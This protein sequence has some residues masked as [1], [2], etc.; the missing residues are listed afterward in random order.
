[1]HTHGLTKL[2]TKKQ[3]VN[4]TAQSLL[5]AYDS[6]KEIEKKIAHEQLEL[7]NATESK[8]LNENYVSVQLFEKQKRLYR[9]P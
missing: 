8:I 9:A 1:M 7:D 6:Q 3:Q 5:K 2:Y 4:E